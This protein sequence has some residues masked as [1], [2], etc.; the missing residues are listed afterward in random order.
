MYQKFHNTNII[1]IVVDKRIEIGSFSITYNLL[2]FTKLHYLHSILIRTHLN[3]F[4]T[5]AKEVVF[6]TLVCFCLLSALCKNY[7]R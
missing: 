3:N 6:S 7:L 1:A 5:Y 4:V 2:P